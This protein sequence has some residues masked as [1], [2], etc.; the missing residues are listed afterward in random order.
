MKKLTVPSVIYNKCLPVLPF[1]YNH[2]MSPFLAP[3]DLESAVLLAKLL[4]PQTF[5]TEGF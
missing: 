4:G 3:T 1:G 2:I 5:G